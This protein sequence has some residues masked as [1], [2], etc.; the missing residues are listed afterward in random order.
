MLKQLLNVSGFGAYKCRN[1]ASSGRLSL[2]GRSPGLDRRRRRRPLLL[3]TEMY[4]PISFVI[5]S[6][7]KSKHNINIL[8]WQVGWMGGAFMP[9]DLYLPVITCFTIF[10]ILVD[11][12]PPTAHFWKKKNK[13]CI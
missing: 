7:I 6:V 3:L 1:V 2:G 11:D 5:K 4:G 13:T 9:S 10:S 12:M 8:F